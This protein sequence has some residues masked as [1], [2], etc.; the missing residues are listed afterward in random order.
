MTDIDCSDEYCRE[1][2]IQPDC[3]EKYDSIFLPC[4]VKSLDGK[5]FDGGVYMND[6]ED[7]SYSQTADGCT[8]DLMVS[9]H[10]F[11]YATIDC[12]A[13]YQMYQMTHD[14]QSFWKWQDE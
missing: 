4:E 12:L 14:N 6:I 8:K 5:S 9:S 2:F 11:C 13:E 10:G 7:V 1:R 3:I